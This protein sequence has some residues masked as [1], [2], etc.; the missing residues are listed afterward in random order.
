MFAQDQGM[1]YGTVTTKDDQTITGQIRWDDEE[2]YWTDLFNAV[3]KDNQSLEYLDKKEFK[4]LKRRQINRSNS[5]FGFGLLRLFNIGDYDLNHEFACHFGY[6]Q[7][8]EP[9]KVQQARITLRNG[10]S[11]RIG[12]AG[13]NDI[14]PK[15]MVFTPTEDVKIDWQVI[16]TIE[17]SSVPQD[18][19]SKIGRPLYGTVESRIGTFTGLIEWDLDERL[20]SDILDGEHDGEDYEIPF[21]KIGHIKNEG[22]GSTIT[23]TT[24]K[25]VY[26]DDSNDVDD[27]NDGIA[28][29]HPDFGRVIIDWVDFDEITFSETPEDLLPSFE[30]FKQIDRIQGLVTSRQG[31]EFTGNLVFDL[32]ESYQFELLQGYMANS[33]FEIPF[34]SIDSLSI[35][36]PY[37]CSLVLKS[38]LKLQLE[39][40]RD[41][42]Y[43]NSGLLISQEGDRPE[44]LRWRDVKTIAF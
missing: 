3:K 5:G 19:S 37:S 33:K 26:L 24:G 41:V 39:V 34:Y 32:D 27:D 4:Q 9:L 14:G 31:K 8:I 16:E 15:I 35:D 11:F 20:T 2:V 43:R 21:R 36:G 28:I 44:Y 29:T 40:S 17:F 42:T 25:K 38:G 12:G 1:L 13:Y 18:W 10:D 23:S 30:D 6:I 7:K 22:N